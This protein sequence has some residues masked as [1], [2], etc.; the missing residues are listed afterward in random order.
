MLDELDIRSIDGNDNSLSENVCGIPCQS[1]S[2][3]GICLDASECASLGGTSPLS[4]LCKQDECCFGFDQ[5]SVQY[6]VNKR[7]CPTYQPSDVSTIKGNDNVDF[8]VV[9]IERNHLSD[10]SYYDF[11]NNAKD[12]TMT[13]EIACAFDSMA[14]AADEA[15]LQL[16][17]TSGFRTYERQEYFW[18]CYHNCDPFI[19]GSNCNPAAVPGTSSH[20]YGKALDISVGAEGSATLTWMRQNA[21][22]FG[23]F[24]L[25]SPSEPWHWDYLGTDKG[26][27]CATNDGGG[28]DNDDDDDI[29]ADGNFRLST[30][31]KSFQNDFEKGKE[32]H[33]FAIDFLDGNIGCLYRKQ[34]SWDY[35]NVPEISREAEEENGCEHPSFLELSQVVQSYDDSTSFQVKAVDALQQ[36]METDKPGI[37]TQFLE[38]WNNI[39]N[40]DATTFLT[41]GFL[42]V[43]F[44]RAWALG[45][46]QECTKDTTHCAWGKN[47]ERWDS[48]RGGAIN[49]S[50][51]AA[52]S[53]KKNT[54]DSSPMLLKNIKQVSEDTEIPLSVL[55][56]LASR[57]TGFGSLLGKKNCKAG[58]GDPDSKRICP[59]IG[60]NQPSFHC[61]GYGVLQVDKCSH[62]SKITAAQKDPNG[63]Y[64][65]SII[66]AAA[67]IFL[68]CFKN[69]QAKFTAA[70]ALAEDDKTACLEWTPAYV[71]KATTTC[72]NA[73]IG[74]VATILR[75]DSGSTNDDYGSDVLV[76][77]MWFQSQSE[78]QQ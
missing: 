13:F 65:I 29:V 2:S 75:T 14:A 41:T 9:K 54:L 68:D 64:G 16:R 45:A 63:P 39:D 19:C 1:S 38:Y 17:I 4:G 61:W 60:I 76:Q 42:P 72:Y 22:N 40:C 23:F 26:L 46:F 18:N 56:A 66:S 67:N 27:D 24:E 59:A 71:L 51:E 78:F 25:K 33:K 28:D 74:G 52:K 48:N 44:S 58:W 32:E 70:S 35:K 77:A 49:R 36:E 3:I 69:V 73:G 50:I 8:L 43:K 31:L 10:P 53:R 20:G 30:A 11:S 55:L 62:M 34:F 37:W 47:K 7:I 21:N 6:G 12:N 57:E 15:G 5:N